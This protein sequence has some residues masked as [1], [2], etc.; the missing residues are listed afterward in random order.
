MHLNWISPIGTFYLDDDDGASAHLARLALLVDLAQTGPLAELLVRVDTDERDLVLVAQ[1]GDEL[2]VLRLVAALG[3][4]GEHRLSLV[5]R[6]ARLVDAVDESIDDE[7]LLQ[8]LLQGG[9]HVH[10]SSDHGHGG[11]ITASTIN[12]N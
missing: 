12:N 11:H 5:E 10:G 2:L 1:R 7:R 8:H 9:V 6:L 4:N 3:Q